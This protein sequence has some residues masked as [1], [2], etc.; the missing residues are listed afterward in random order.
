MS[1]SDDYVKTECVETQTI[2]IENQ[3][4]KRINEN[5]GAKG[6]MITGGLCKVHVCMVDDVQTVPA[7][8]ITAPALSIAV[9]YDGDGVC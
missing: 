5:N 4:Q 9:C 6:C 8:V 3:S 2:C 1:Q 7:I